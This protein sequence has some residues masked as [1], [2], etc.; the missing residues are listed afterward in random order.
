MIPPW[1]PMGVEGGN[2]CVLVAQ[3]AVNYAS[4]G[5]LSMQP[6]AFLLQ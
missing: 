2:T 4:P 5:V 3:L 1:Y 6:H